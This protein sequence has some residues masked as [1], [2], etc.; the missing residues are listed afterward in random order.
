[1]NQPIYFLVLNQK[2][3]MFKLEDLF[4]EC[5]LYRE[6]SPRAEPLVCLAEDNACTVGHNCMESLVRRLKLVFE[7][8]LPQAQLIL[9][10]FRKRNVPGLGAGV[11]W[12]DFREPRVFTVN[13]RAWERVKRRGVVFQFVPGESFFLTGKA[14]EP[15]P[16][17]APL[18]V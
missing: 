16:V 2:T 13:P 17:S 1:M 15:E 12:R 4:P 7:E 9:L 10:Y 11:F 18:S 8:L 5:S 3:A 6:Q 14:P